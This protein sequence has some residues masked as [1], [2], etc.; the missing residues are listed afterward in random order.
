MTW[1]NG[2]TQTSAPNGGAPVVLS[3]H[4]RPTP[5]QRFLSMLAPVALF[6]VYS[7]VPL[8]HPPAPPEALWFLLFYD[9]LVLL[10]ALI[11]GSGRTRLGYDGVQV[12]LAGRTRTIRWLDVDR[13]ELRRRWGATCVVLHTGD[14]RSTRLP[15]PVDGG[16]GAI[17]RDPE[18]DTKL[19]T[20]TDWWSAC[21]RAHG[22][23]A[24]PP[25]GR[26]VPAGAAEGAVRA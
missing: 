13:M 19:D 8:L 4:F 10:T 21:R 11:P 20:L 26:A 14:G 7:L 3:I 25:Q 18:F 15:A 1:R 24:P 17:A 16:I 5:L 6:D 9:A 23:P 2:V 22:L 12:R